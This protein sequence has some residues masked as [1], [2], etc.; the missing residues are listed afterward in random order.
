[1]L[2]EVQGWNAVIILLTENNV[3]DIHF[4]TSGF[5]D[6]PRIV[7]SSEVKLCYFNHPE[8]FF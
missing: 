3:L 8:F 2:F 1:M 5:S 6:N 4:S 7:W